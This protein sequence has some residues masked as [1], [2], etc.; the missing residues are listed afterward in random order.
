MKKSV[1]DPVEDPDKLDGEKTV[2]CLGI[3]I[4][5]LLVAIYLFG[6]FINYIRP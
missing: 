2:G 6:Q 1:K 3:G 4:V 5:L